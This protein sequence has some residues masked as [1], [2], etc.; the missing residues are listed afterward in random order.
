MATD[1]VKRPNYSDGQYLRPADFVA[2]QQYHRD[3]Q[4]RANLGHHTW[5]IFSGLEL[6]EVVREGVTRYVDIFVQPAW[7]LA[8]LGRAIEVFYAYKLNAS[9]LHQQANLGW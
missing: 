6:I 3:A 1:D 2:E 7:A 5:G 8:G 4:R 9:I